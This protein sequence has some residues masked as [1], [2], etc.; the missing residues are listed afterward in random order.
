MEERISA[1]KQQLLDHLDRENEKGLRNLFEVTH[2]SDLGAVFEKVEVE[3]A[4]DLFQYLPE[5]RKPDILEELT[6]GRS[7]RLLAEYEEVEMADLLEG[8]APDDAADIFLTC[9]KDLQE[10]LLSRIDDDN[11]RQILIDLVSYPADSAGGIMTTEYIAV[12]EEVTVQE[13]IET[14]RRRADDAEMFYYLYAL[15][16]DNRLSGVLAMR[17]LLQ[18]EE[19]ETIREIA[20]R[21]VVS[22]RIDDDQEEVAKKLDRYN[23]FALPVIDHQGHM[24]G[25]ITVDDAVGILEREATEDIYKQAGISPYQELEAERSIRLTRSSF[26]TN[27]SLRVPWLAVVFLGT[28]VTAHSV[29]LFE[30][31]LETYVELAFFMPVIAA[32]GGNVG[33]QSTTIFV[34][35]LTLGQIDTDSFWKP[36][37][38]EIYKTGIGV[39]LS[40]GVGLGLT[41]WAWQLYLRGAA[42][43]GYALDFALAVGVA[44]F[45]AI[46]AA[47]ANGFLIPWLVSVM[48]A[49]PATASNPLLTT[50]QDIV[51]IFIYFACAGFFLTMM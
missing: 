50:V 6:P 19:H 15:D 35:G 43:G 40:F 13:A 29:S 39:G 44:M 12:N 32:M 47:S 24:R 18:A 1:I 27:L 17:D 14:A 22:V 45:M 46:V 26:W 31:Y 7:V 48:G 34:R 25:I 3:G 28:L 23:L 2:P 5:D 38:A 11:F 36:F 4:R 21:D 41:A 9:E 10:R 33:A 49:D 30:N 51:G 8:M 42:P 16:E 37:A 20:E